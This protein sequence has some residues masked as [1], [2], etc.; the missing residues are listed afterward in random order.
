M[1]KLLLLTTAVSTLR[2]FPWR[3]IMLWAAPSLAVLGIVVC[4][5][6]WLR[7]AEGLAVAESNSTTLRNVG[8]LIGGVVAIGFAVWRGRVADRQSKAAQSQAETAQ[9]QAETSRHSLLN[10]RYQKGVEMLESNVLPVRIGAIHA[11]GLLAREEPELYYRQFR[12]LGCAFVRRPPHENEQG[13]G[14]K[15]T[16]EDVH[17]VMLALGDRTTEQLEVEQRGSARLPL[18]GVDLRNHDLHKLDLS[19]AL[20]PGAKLDGVIL[21]DSKLRCAIFSNVNLSD[22][23]LFNADL[24]GAALCGADLTKTDLSD[25]ILVG[26]NLSK[27]LYTPNIRVEDI[28]LLLLPTSSARGANLTDARLF[29]ANFENAVLS[30]ANVAGARFYEDVRVEGIPVNTP[31]YGLRQ[32]Q[33]DSAIADPP[34]RPPILDGMLD[35]KTGKALV[36]KK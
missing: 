16:R 32:E 23:F 11:L 4:F 27:T 33:L 34:D 7:A 6:P 9:K 29:G 21:A 24:S 10:D 18:W 25:A 5:W 26:A 30:G 1:R 36:W 8:L 20:F 17:A 19:K 28:D 13:T 2:A 22:G 35:A 14:L 31:A 3:K 12:E 15:G